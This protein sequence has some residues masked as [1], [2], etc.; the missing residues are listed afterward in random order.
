MKKLNQMKIG[1]HSRQ[2]NHV[3]YMISHVDGHFAFLVVPNVLKIPFKSNNEVIVGRPGE[4]NYNTAKRTNAV[5]LFLL[6][7]HLLHA[8][9]NMKG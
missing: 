3:G 6:M 2:Q 4:R 1:T 7:S 8:S 9:V 5:V